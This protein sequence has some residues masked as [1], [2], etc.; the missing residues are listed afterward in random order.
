MVDLTIK[1]ELSGLMSEEINFNLASVGLRL[2]CSR[3]QIILQTAEQN[4][5][6]FTKLCAHSY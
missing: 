5:V 6:D 3:K 2:F 4:E 1:G